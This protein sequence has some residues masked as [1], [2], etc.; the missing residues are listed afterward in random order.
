MQHDNSEQIDDL[1]AKGK[2]FVAYDII[3]CGAL[4]TILCMENICEIAFT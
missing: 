3:Y 2:E 4:Q 1:H